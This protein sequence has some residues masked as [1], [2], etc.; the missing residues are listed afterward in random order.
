M[1]YF[2]LLALLSTLV[3]FG[4]SI[5]YKLYLLTIFL[6]L[7][8]FYFLY[9]F[10]KKKEYT[11]NS[12]FNK[13]AILASNIILFLSLL[14][15]IRLVQI[16]IFNEDIYDEKVKSQI[17]R[18]DI[19]YGDRGNIYDSSGK[20]LA[21]NQ[22]IYTLGV[23][24]SSL[25]DK[26]TTYPGIEKILEEIYRDKPGEKKR[27]L[28]ALEE[29]NRAGR[30]YKVVARN[31][32][33][34]EKE[35]ISQIAKEYKLTL[36]EIQFDRSIKRTYYK[37][38]L[39]KNLIGFIGYTQKSNS[40]K[41]GVYGLEKEYE[42]Y[43]KEKSVKRQNIYTKNRKIKLPFAQDSITTNLNGKNIHTTIDNELQ[44]ILNEEVEK[45][46][47]SSGSE[48][49][50]GVI[51][52][53]NNGKILATSY[54]TIFKNRAL[55]N[56]IFQ[57]Q[58][59][60]GSIFKP[61]IVAAA[62]DA[63]LVR[64]QTK[65]DIGDGTIRKY[66]HTIKE[67]SRNT[68]GILSTEEVLKKSSNVG[69]VMIGDKFTN[70]EF[71]EYLKK[72]GLY[73]RTGVDFPGELKPYTTPYKRWDGLKKSTMSF[74]QGIV[75]TPIQMITAFS[76][77]INGG[78][79]YKPYLV[80]KITDDKG[81]VI[82]RNLPSVRGTTISKELSDDMREMLEEVVSD[83]T[84]KRGAVEGYRVGGKTG[85]AQLS[86]KGG[87]L[88]E[89]YLSSFIGFFPVDKPKYTILVMFLKPKGE[90]IFEKFGGATAAPV[91]GNIV[92]RISKTKNILSENISKLSKVDKFEKISRDIAL[93]VTMPDLK[94][95]PPKDV[96]EIF[97]KSDI[98]VKIKGVG[99]V[100]EQYPK[101]GESLE[102]VREIRII[103]D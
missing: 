40:E 19:F 97:S 42:E 29:G 51:I 14:I 36:N 57:N 10:A 87:Y 66:R 74:G 103:L 83:G 4:F 32:T 21:F 56:P 55:R 80:D 61:I 68:K 35:R 89:N 23:N 70:Q 45:K 100:K 50:Y 13:R 39:Y 77:L 101:A 11:K 15:V 64:K 67:A 17:R 94:G 84:A 53:P 16:Q 99:L 54:Y 93:D 72:F 26:E 37:S 86:T 25:Y 63:N 18:N 27:Y 28:K 44:F 65:F 73:D 2:K 98:E 69:M 33:E 47:T 7:L 52:D 34:K 20:S 5:Y 43:L 85:T 78:I 62:L 59:E 8:F 30:R 24:P 41:I 12:N 102:K 92:R 96:I 49:A 31:L 48:E 82:R 6:F 71:E 9:I 75:V 46:F 79:L 3:G 58:M 76:S 95:M 38:D 90:T 88:K 91:F 22:N 81:V 60:P 1:R